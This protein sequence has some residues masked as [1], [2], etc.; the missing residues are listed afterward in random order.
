MKTTTKHNALKEVA[1]KPKLLK[2]I[3]LLA[4]FVQT[5][6]LEV[7]HG[8]M[9]KKYVNKSQHYSY[10]GMVSRMQLAVIDH[11]CNVGRGVAT[12]TS[13]DARYKCVF[14]KLQKQ[15]VAKPI[16]EK[17][18]LL[19]DAILLKKVEIEVPDLERPHLPK[20]IA[21]NPRGNKEDIITR[22]VSRFQ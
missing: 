12:T 7:F 22:H 8:S 16:Y 11:N 15:W 5:G 9:P 4:D 10:N 6:C 20:N 19:S 14:P 21:P 13:G 3:R 2:D 18:Y 1:W 17:S